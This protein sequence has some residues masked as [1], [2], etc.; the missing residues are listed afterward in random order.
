MV[1]CIVYRFTLFDDGIKKI[2]IY[3]MCLVVKS[4]LDIVKKRAAENR[5]KGGII[6]HTK[7]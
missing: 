4:A 6:Q 2:A 7:G 1:I 3:Q 5:R